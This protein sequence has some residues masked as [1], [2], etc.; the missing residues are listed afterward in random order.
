MRNFPSNTFI[1]IPF[2]DYQN[3]ARGRFEKYCDWSWWQTWGKPLCASA[4]CLVFSLTHIIIDISPTYY[5]SH[6]KVLWGGRITKIETRHN[7]STIDKLTF[8][9]KSPFLLLANNYGMTNV[10][11]FLCMC[12]VSQQCRVCI[13]GVVPVELIHDVIR[14]WFYGMSAFYDD[15]LQNNLQ[16]DWR[17]QYPGAGDNSTF[18][19]WMGV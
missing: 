14:V 19:V 16:C 13:C 15:V 5:I 12:I 18:F 8:V 3:L 4:S 6:T 1:I 9:C 7:S 2:S 17:R 10:I 11:P